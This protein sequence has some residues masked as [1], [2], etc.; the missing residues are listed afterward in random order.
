[1]DA[2]RTCTGWAAIVAWGLIAIAYLTAICGTLFDTR[3]FGFGYGPYGIGGLASAAIVCGLIGLMRVAPWWS[4][5]VA[6]APATLLG[7]LLLMIF[8][9]RWLLS[10]FDTPGVRMFVTTSDRVVALTID[11]S[12]DPATT[13]QILDVLA[14]HEVK[15]TFFVISN[16]AESHPDLIRRI[17]A[18]GHELGNHQ[19]CDEPGFLMPAELFAAD[20]RRARETLKQYGE[21]RWLRP[22]GG[23]TTDAMRD[24]AN[25]QGYQVVLGS[26]FPLDSHI[27]SVNFAAGYVERRAFPG[28]IIVLHDG[29]GRGERTAE[30]LRRVLPRLKQ[31]GFGVVPYGEL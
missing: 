16:S 29:P 26:V 24:E 7:L 11:D 3:G 31:A 10:W 13:P 9:P 28:A 30:V 25:R 2:V 15:V 1:M 19:T 12:V 4:R 20:I 27:A 18:E 14:Q 6:F 23:I 22:G 8:P 17:V 5:L 21:V